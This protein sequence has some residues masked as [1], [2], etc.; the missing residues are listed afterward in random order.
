MSMGPLRLL[1][2]QATPFCNLNCSY[3]YLPDK[4]IKRRM[5]LDV[6]EK[7]VERIA[8]SG[9]MHK[10]F[11]VVW[12]AGEPLAAGIKFYQEADE[13]IRRKLPPGVSFKHCLQTNGTLIT[14]EW[15]A[16]FKALPMNVG[17][18]VDGP[19][20]LNDKFR[21][22]RRGKGSLSQI[23]RGMSCLQEA[24]I[25]F[26]T[27]SVVTKEAVK[28]A[29]AIFHY[30]YSWGPDCMGFNV[31]EIEGVHAS[32]SLQSVTEAEFGAFMNRMHE[33]SFEVGEPNLVRE[34]RSA[35]AAIMGSVRKM[36]RVPPM[37]NNPLSIIN[38][39]VDGN[40]S[41]FSPELLG[42]KH[43]SYGD[44]ILGNFL[45]SGIEE[46]MTS[47]KFQRMTAEIQAG[48]QACQASCEYFHFCGGG[49]PSNKLF[50][51]G[52]FDSA[53]TLHCRMTKKVVTDIVLGRMET[54]LAHDLPAEY[55]ELMA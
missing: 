14:K 3:C 34:F 28:Q 20:A 19:A 37:E 33:L 32:S 40:F 29:E 53:E 50:E 27:I 12:H 13:A 2:L 51:N 35:H 44:F 26:H 5:S 24:E 17:V 41:S 30:L 48:V 15:C 54:M 43:E 47:P 25:S 42:M 10:E 21:V 45:H 22:D 38:V 23:E 1:L 6:I 55:A 7:S 16:L 36:P 46:L 4:S 52:S 9:L 11:S 8:A 39:D 49:A 31:E 18:S